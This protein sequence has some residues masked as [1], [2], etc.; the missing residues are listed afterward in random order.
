M[1]RDLRLPG[2]I[3]FD[4]GMQNASAQWQRPVG[5]ADTR[6]SDPMLLFFT[7]GTTGMPKMVMHIIL[8]TCAYSRQ[9]SGT[10]CSRMEFISQFRIRDGAS[11][12]GE[13]SMGNGLQRQWCLYMIMISSSRQKCCA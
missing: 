5:D 6:L 3:S 4:E 10:M 9:Y 8:Y 1:V 12:S 7:S 2:W 13:N 11:V